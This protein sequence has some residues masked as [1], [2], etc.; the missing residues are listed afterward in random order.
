MQLAHRRAD[1]AGEHIRA[2]QRP[3]RNNFAGQRGGPSPAQ[4]A[5]RRCTPRLLDHDTLS[6]AQIGWRSSTRSCPPSRRISGR[7]MRIALAGSPY[8]WLWQQIV[9]ARQGSKALLRRHV[10][11]RLLRAAG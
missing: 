9:G 2:G 1:E 10:T 11:D 5:I 6:A 8:P 7:S 3:A 4:V